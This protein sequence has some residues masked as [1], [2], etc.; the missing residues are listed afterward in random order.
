MNVGDRNFS[1]FWHD[2]WL[3]DSPLRVRFPR[4][5]L[6]V[7]DLNSLVSSCGRW[8]DGVWEWSSLGGDN[9]TLGRRPALGSSICHLLLSLLIDIMCFEAIRRVDWDSR[10][11]LEELFSLQGTFSWIRCVYYVK[12]LLSLLFISFVTVDLFMRSGTPLS[13]GWVLTLWWSRIFHLC[14]S[15]SFLWVAQRD[16][17]VVWCSSSMLFSG[18]FGIWRTCVFP[19]EM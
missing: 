19:L 17:I 1:L 11:G 8:I 13:A 16:A 5:F 6:L 15:S 7:M 3:G 18:L 14:S 10:Q 4:L 9:C 12:L 2:A